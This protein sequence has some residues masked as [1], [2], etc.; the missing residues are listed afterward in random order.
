MKKNIQNIEVKTIK[1]KVFMKGC[2]ITGY[3]IGTIL[4]ITMMTAHE[5]YNLLKK[6]KVIKP[7]ERFNYNYKTKK[8]EKE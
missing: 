7:K 4:G 6:Y 2:E 1:E 8:I 3:A 5:V